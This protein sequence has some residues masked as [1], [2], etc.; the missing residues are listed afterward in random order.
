V[1]VM[2]TASFTGPNAAELTI[3]RKLT[4]VEPRR[5]R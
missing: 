1:I 2:A 5:R 4:V 3:E